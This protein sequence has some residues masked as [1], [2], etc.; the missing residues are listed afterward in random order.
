M[1]RP[2][3]FEACSAPLAAAAIALMVAGTSA[4]A[5]QQKLPPPETMQLSGLKQPVDILLDHWGVPHI[6]AANEA[7]LFF[8]QGFNTARDRLFQMDLWRRRG[9]GELAEVFG[10]E[11]VEQ[12]KASRLFL[13]RGDMKQEWAMYSPDAQQIAAQFAAGVN[14]YIGWL[15]DHPQQMP[16][17]FKLLKYQP[18]LWSPEDVVRI[19]SHGLGGNLLHEAERAR[20]LCIAGRKAEEIR[21][22]LEP[23]WP[24]LVPAGLNPCLPQDV[25]KVFSLATAGVRL[26]P[27]ATAEAHPLASLPV[28]EEETTNEPSYGSNNWAISP[29]KS[30]TGRAILASDPH[31]D[32]V[33]PSVRYLQDLNA[34]TL[35]IEGMGEPIAPGVSFAHN[36]WIAYAGTVF[37]ID[38]EDLYV[39]ELN[40]AN[41][42][43]YK[44]QGKWVAFR[45]VHE[46]IKV[47]GQGAV[48]AELKF[49][50]HGPVIYLDRET[51]RAFAVRTAWLEPGTSPYFASVALMRARTFP[52]Y[53][54]AVARWGKP[55][56]NMVYADVKGNIAWTPRGFAPIRPN[57][58][59]LMPVP[60]DGRYEWAGKWT[61][62]QLPLSY[63]PSQ[64]Y[65]TT[66][67]EMNLP[68]GYPY[69]QRKL[70]FE[71]SDPSRHRRIDEVLSSRPKVSLEDSMRLQNDV[72]SIPARRLLA[73]LE[74]LTSDN[75]ETLAALK[76]LGEWDAHLD[77]DSA[78][79]ALEEVWFTRHL[80]PAFKA[81]T[82]SNQAAG[83]FAA[84]STQVLLD[85]LEQP[86]TRFSPDATGQRDKLLLTTLGAAYGEMENL[87]GP[88]ASK[89]TWG[90]LHH[91]FSEHPFS[92]VTDEAQQK[93]LNVGPVETGGGAF[94]VNASSYRARDFL[95]TS[96]PSVRMVLDVGNWDNSRAVNYPGESGDPNSPHYRDL[97]PM[98]VGGTYFPLLYSRPAVEQ[99]TEKRIRLVPNPNVR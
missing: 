6:Y 70:G 11:F 79:A 32:Y 30:A 16:Y 2:I 91:N 25:L 83:L 62:A 86:Q 29:R 55:A 21:Q 72:L 8:A 48:A 1:H 74:T 40:P 97:A 45:Q 47:K 57:W 69:K 43:E 65:L 80:Q 52:E 51:N 73:L 84:P 98:W 63:N 76:L 95:Q 10:P 38:Q 27:G 35:H 4:L 61:A 71:W 20:V 99:A 41:P 92:Q 9:L 22:R 5:Q 7:D 26:A 68:P 19:R 36:D 39:Y 31:R 37:W 88:D 66:S 42:D 54:K 64:G 96:G 50:R 53:E 60:G 90:K 82:L 56:L 58:D 28:D 85:G 14:A 13:Y 24:N 75:A 93:Q 77:S 59:G 3:F 23:P 49:T 33:Q 94:T 78:A 17:E 44:Y 15:A 18:A 81:A 89:W 34:P 46:Q 87:Q 67:N 12:D